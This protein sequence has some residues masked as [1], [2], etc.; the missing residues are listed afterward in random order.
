LIA[1]CSTTR[2]IQVPNDKSDFT[3][4]DYSASRRGAYLINNNG[5]KIIVSEPVPDIA[6]DITASLGLSAETIG[7]LA[8]PEL[9]A[10]YASK[11]VDLANRSQTLQVL[12]ES[13]FRLSEMGA[14][15]QLSVD[16]RVILFSK[17]LDTV[18]LIS[19]TEFANSNAPK[20]VKEE[21]LKS[22]LQDTQSG[23]ITIKSDSE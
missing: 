3:V 8:S 23:T 22:F 9:K 11:V 5:N 10:E 15:S 14:S 20:E 6:K 18:K 13:L 16:Q 21:T 4:I 1:G 17:V 12:R 2:K 19:A 7:D